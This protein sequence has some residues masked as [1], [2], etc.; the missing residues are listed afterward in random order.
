VL[1]VFSGETHGKGRG[2][3]ELRPSIATGKKAA[4][5]RSGHW[6]SGRTSEVNKGWVAKGSALLRSSGVER[7][8][9]GR[10]NK[11]L[12]N[13]LYWPM[14][15]RRHKCSRG[16]KEPGLRDISKRTLANYGCL[17]G[18][19]LQRIGVPGGVVMRLQ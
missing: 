18:E 16:E 11:E 8:E 7:I 17:M 15:V 10:V 14:V 12:E 3:H 5:T 13:G 2:G 9:S 19:R 4:R 1:A 6:N